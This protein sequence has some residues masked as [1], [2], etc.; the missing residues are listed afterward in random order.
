MCR[1]LILIS[2][3]SAAEERREGKKE[4][5][6]LT[7]LLTYRKNYVYEAE[8]LHIPE[9]YNTIPRWSHTSFIYNYGAARSL[10]PSHMQQPEFFFTSS[11]SIGKTHTSCLMAQERHAFSGVVTSPSIPLSWSISQPRGVKD[12][13]FSPGKSWGSARKEVKTAENWDDQPWLR[14]YC[15]V[16][17]RPGTWK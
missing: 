17:R 2:F 11:G 10:K 4:K 3:S 8:K 14:Y 12:L 5:W 1:G 9:G 15:A 7:V 13:W 6:R 16:K